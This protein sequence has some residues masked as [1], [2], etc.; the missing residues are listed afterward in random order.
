M[1]TARSTPTRA[2]VL[3]QTTDLTVNFGGLVA[4]DAVTF[5]IRRGEILG[6]IGPERGGQDDVLQRDH[7]CLPAEL[8]LG[9]VR[10]RADR[11]DQAPRD[12]PA[13][14]RADF[15]EH[16]AVR[17]DDRAGER[18]GGHRRPAPH[19]GP[20]RA[21]PIAHGTGVRSARRS[22]G[23]QRC[24]TSSGSRTAVRRRP[25]TCPTAISAGWRSRGRWPPS[26]SCCA[27]TSLRRASIPARSPR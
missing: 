17:G 7:G 10:R 1:C 19:V 25:R 11:Q 20:R 13:R 5:N 18:D 12:H 2:R 23:R 6:L 15:P 22:K 24:C 21:V 3:L 14:N 27:W 4:L 8:G 16:P 26:P 9:D